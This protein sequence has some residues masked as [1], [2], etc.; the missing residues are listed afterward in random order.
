MGQEQNNQ[1]QLTE[2]PANPMPSFEQNPALLDTKIPSETHTIRGFEE[3]LR[4]HT[5]LG[6]GSIG[7]YIRALNSFFSKYDTPTIENLNSFIMKSSRNARSYHVKSAI[8]QYLKY[9]GRE[10]DFKK[11]I[12]IKIKSREKMGKFLTEPEIIFI[13]NNIPKEKFRDIALLQF[14]LGARAME[15]L[16]LKEENVDYSG[17]QMR[18]KLVGKGDKSR[19]VFLSKQFESV[20]T[21]YRTDSKR[22]YLFFDKEWE[23]LS[24]KESLAKFNGMRSNQYY[25][26]LKK[27]SELGTHDLRRNFAEILRTKGN[28]LLVIKQTLGHASLQTTEKYFNENPE[29]VKE[30]MIK[31]QEGGI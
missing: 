28:D 31:F 1:P 20:L 15:I 23:E 9:V 2:E 7:V 14:R 8:R 25:V 24:P 13:I 10:E 26:Q 18:I 12:P 22:G 19:V 5:V 21:K 17:E 4:K 6:E 3:Y 27:A 29:R 30:A 11:M 16:T